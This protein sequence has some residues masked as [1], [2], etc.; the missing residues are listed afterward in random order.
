MCIVDRTQREIDCEIDKL[1]VEEKKSIKEIHNLA[2]KNQHVSEILIVGSCKDHGK[3]CSE[4]QDKA[5]KSFSY[6]D[7]TV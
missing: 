6:K 4:N 1:H 3:E 2:L 5:S 7:L